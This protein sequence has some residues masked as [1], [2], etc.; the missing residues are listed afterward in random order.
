MKKILIDVS[1]G[2]L[3]VLLVTIFEFLVTLPFGEFGQPDSG[4]YSSMINRELLLT[5][6]PGALATFFLTWLFKTKSVS[7][8]I[9]RAIAGTV[10]LALW[11]VI[12]GVGNRNLREIF[13]G[14]GVYTLLVCVFAGPI[15]YAKIKHTG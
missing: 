10:I 13:A 5:A 9:R 8:A 3:V 14:F 2:L 1:F 11:Y 12:I 15:I 7:D 4:S 6:L